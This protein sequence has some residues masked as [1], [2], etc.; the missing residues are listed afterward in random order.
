MSDRFLLTVFFFLNL[1][2]SV[3]Q[4]PYFKLIFPADVND[5]PLLFVSEIDSFQNKYNHSIEKFIKK[6][7]KRQPGHKLLTKEEFSTYSLIEY[8]YAVYPTFVTVYNGSGSG[9][10]SVISY[11]FYNRKNDTKYR[12]YAQAK[13][14]PKGQFDKYYPQ[15]NLKAEKPQNF[16]KDLLRIIRNLDKHGTKKTFEK[17]QVHQKKDRIIFW[18]ITG[19]IT[20]AVPEIGILIG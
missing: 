20:L 10:K 12:V 11:F 13:H 14:V 1:G 6:D 9:S 3:S 7:N 4:D 17:E 15:R 18:S 8:K 19:V 5:Y 2:T 16:P